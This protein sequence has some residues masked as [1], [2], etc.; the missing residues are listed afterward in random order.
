MR[1]P[2]AELLG[3]GHTKPMISKILFILLNFKKLKIRKG[4]TTTQLY[5]ELN[6]VNATREKRL[7]YAQMVI[8]NPDLMPHLLE[9]LF[10][11]DDKLSCRAAWILEFV[12][13]ENLELLFPYL[14]NFTEQIHKVHLDSAVR[15]IAKIC[16]FL[17]K[18][19]YSKEENP[20]KTALQQKHQE[21]IIETCFDYMINDEKIAPKAYAMNTL[22]LLGKDFEWIHPELR[23]ILERD[24]PNQSAGFKARAKHIL[25]K[26][27]AS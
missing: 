22:Y 15:P 26:I 5:S 16:E 19:Y 18:S 25:S 20:I 10:W 27:K 3:S 24:Y 12:C 8:K 13:K 1:L 7:H 2:A 23:Q 4:L 17:I 14:D 11:V 6:F 9:I 21:K